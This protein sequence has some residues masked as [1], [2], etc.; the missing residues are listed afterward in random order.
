ML[1]KMTGS[2][3]EKQALSE[4]SIDSNSGKLEVHFMRRRIRSS[5]FALLQSPLFQTM[6]H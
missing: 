3:S 6:V 1:R 5:V 2:D 4:T